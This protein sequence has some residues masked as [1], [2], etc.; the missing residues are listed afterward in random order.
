M[1]VLVIS[2]FWCF[3][4]VVVSFVAVFVYLCG[5]FVVEFCSFVGHVDVFFV[6]C[7][8]LLRLNIHYMESDEMKPKQPRTLIIGLGQI[9]YHNA[10][11]LTKLGMNVEGFDLKRNAISQALE[12]NV[13]RKEA[14]TFENY[15]YYILCVSTHD[16]E[17]MKQPNLDGLLEIAERLEKEAK[18]G[19]LV[20][21]E[22]T[23]SRGV[24]NKISAILGHKLHVAHVPHRFYAEEKKEHGVK[25]LRVLGGCKPCCTRKALDFYAGKLRIP[26]CSVGTVELAELSKIVENSY[27]FLQIAFAE[28]LKIFCNEE[29][30]DFDELRDAV[31][32]KW[33]TRILEAREGIGG[34]CLPK[35]TRMLLDAEKRVIPFSTLATAIEVDDLYRTKL[36]KEEGLQIVFPRICANIKSSC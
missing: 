19:G 27:R 12:A 2:W 36:C 26:V 31:N 5:R 32:S 29:G 33:N 23:I 6:H 17:D 11:Y 22:S 35:D 3:L 1:V 10:E 24:S 34:H 28:E 9:G 16:P 8:S 15:D 30:L 21:V 14:K 18:P 7:K 20:C 25:Q 13:I 4:F